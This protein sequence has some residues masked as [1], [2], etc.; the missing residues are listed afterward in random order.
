MYV[1]ILTKFSNVG[2]LAAFENMGLLTTFKNVGFLSNYL[3]KDTKQV[4][5]KKLLCSKNT[6][7]NNQ[8][9]LSRNKRYTGSVLE[10]CYF[11]ISLAYLYE[12]R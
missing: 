7:Q 11:I 1:E 4:P 6:N 9:P 3:L 5:I 12:G 8:M 10:I 2:F